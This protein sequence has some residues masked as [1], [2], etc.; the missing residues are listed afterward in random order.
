MI[1]TE[2]FTSLLRVLLAGLIFGAGLPALFALG[3]R[4]M[5]QGQGRI[6]G[7][8]TVARGSTLALATA[9]LL[10][11]VVAFA[12]LLGVLWIT[13]DSLDHYFGVTVF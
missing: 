8:G 2:T 6:D 11:A 7:D 4:L 9:Y 12:V 1:T 3:V 5:G 10:F 13:K